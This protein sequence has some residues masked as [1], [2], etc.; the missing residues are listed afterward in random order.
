MRSFQFCMFGYQ[1]F[2]SCSGH[3]NPSCCLT[4]ACKMQH[5]KPRDFILYQME[6]INFHIQIL[7]RI[8]NL[9]FGTFIFR[10]WNLKWYQLGRT[11]KVKYG[12]LYSLPLS[13]ESFTVYFC[14][15]TSNK[16]VVFNRTQ[17]TIFSS[18]RDLQFVGL[19]AILNHSASLV[20]RTHGL[21]YEGQDD[22]R[23]DIRTDKLFFFS[24]YIT[25]NSFKHQH[26]IPRPLFSPEI[27]RYPTQWI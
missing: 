25:H 16:N 13:M 5:S 26:G 22:T 21:K 15:S 1:C 10:I 17:E 4:K 6:D 20:T 19:P 12:K 14:E 9:E 18:V 3:E 7:V 24:L 2:R 27:K 11:I 8:L 23:T